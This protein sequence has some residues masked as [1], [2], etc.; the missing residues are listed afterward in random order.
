MSS[1]AAQSNQ[2]LT[3]TTWARGPKHNGKVLHAP[4]QQTKAHLKGPHMLA[5]ATKASQASYK[6]FPN[7]KTY[8]VIWGITVW[9]S[10]WQP[11]RSYVFLGTKPYQTK[12]WDW[13][14]SPPAYA[15]TSRATALH[16]AALPKLA[17]NTLCATGSRVRACMEVPKHV[18]TNAITHLH[19][20][21]TRG[22]TSKDKIHSILL[23]KS[24]RF[25]PLQW[26][27]YNKRKLRLQ[28]S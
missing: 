3:W 13:G 10:K 11:T 17:S 26:H 12:A 1:L 6:G 16:H 7:S 20:D 5:I 2:V 18:S 15:N 21:N 23:I 24:Q 19:K 8:R 25:P 9:W 14:R 4:I 27:L 22:H 28:D